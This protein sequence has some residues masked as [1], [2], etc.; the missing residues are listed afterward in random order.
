MGSSTQRCVTLAR[1]K[2]NLT[3][4][5]CRPRPTRNS[6]GKKNQ[7]CLRVRKREPSLPGGRGF[8]VE[9]DGAGGDVRVL[10]N[11][12]RVVVVRAVLLLP[13]RVAHAGH[14]GGEQPG[15]PVVGAP[16]GEDLAVAGLVG[17]EA[18][19]GAEDAQGGGDQELEPAVT[20]QRETEP[21]G[22]H[23]EHQ[24]GKHSDV[25]TDAAFQQARGL[26]ALE[27]FRVA[28]DDGVGLAGRA[29]AGAPKW[30]WGSWTR[31]LVTVTG[32]AAADIRTARSGSPSVQHT[33]HGDAPDVHPG[34][35]SGTVDA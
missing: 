3:E 4:S 27:E 5:I 35:G 32:N 28:Q 8:G 15:G 29:T 13:P 20:D 12:V 16:G 24:A 6:S 31:C 17:Q 10:G 19:L 33:L 9:G 25:E 30:W 21:G 11:D 2:T 34:A 22:G 14:G 26:D 23:Q 7:P 18:Q 1:R